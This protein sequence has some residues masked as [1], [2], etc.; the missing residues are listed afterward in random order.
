ML[1]PREPPVAAVD[2]T[3]SLTGQV[4]DGARRPVAGAIVRIGSRSNSAQ[5]TSDASGRFCF[6]GLAPATYA[7]IVDKDGYAQGVYVGILVR[8]GI[9]AVANVV[10]NLRLIRWIAHPLFDTSRV[11]V[12]GGSRYQR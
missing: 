1:I 12:S 10:L 8:A 5:T 2:S 7:L 3:G 9:S 4:R 11:R 6:I